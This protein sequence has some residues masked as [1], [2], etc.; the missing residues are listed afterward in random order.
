MFEGGGGGRGGGEGV[1]VLVQA[2]YLHSRPKCADIRLIFSICTDYFWDGDSFT[3]SCKGEKNLEAHSYF[4]GKS[5]YRELWK[6]RR[7]LFTDANRKSL[8]RYYI[9]SQGTTRTEHSLFSRPSPISY[10]GPWMSYTHARRNQRNTLIPSGTRVRH[11]RLWVRDWSVTSCQTRKH[12][13]IDCDAETVTSG[14]RLWIKYPWIDCTQSPSFLVPSNWE[15]GASERHSRA[16][17]GEEGRK[18][19]GT[20]SFLFPLPHSPR[21]RLLCS[22]QSRARSCISLAPVSQLLRERKGAA[23]SLHPEW[24]SRQ[25]GWCNLSYPGNALITF[26]E[27]LKASGPCVFPGVRFTVQRSVFVGGDRLDDRV[28]HTRQHLVPKLP[29]TVLEHLAQRGVSVDADVHGH[30]LVVKA[31]LDHSLGQRLVE[32]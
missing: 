4:R 14:W 2:K 5:N 18:N 29:Q 22:L 13:S 10:P 30:E 6:H 12:M 31:R 3:S 11:P 24:V 9:L 17:N 7:F 1:G 25:R 28:T 16:E 26:T 20:L 8:F 19:K 32:P 27:K 15:T 21:G 23:C